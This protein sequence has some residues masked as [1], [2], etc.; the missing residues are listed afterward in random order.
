MP[1]G[2][3]D[4]FI[5]QGTTFVT[6]ITLDDSYG[7]PYDLTNFTVKAQAKKSYYS[8]TISLNFD[9]TI[10]SP[11]DGLI[12]LF[13]TSENTANVS[14]NKLVYDVVITDNDNG[15]VTRVLEGQIHMSPSVTR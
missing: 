13:A 8:N 7:T 15:S 14:A 2:Y 9:A 6:E 11:H 10:T 5:E 12:Q 1:A 4:L 3:Q